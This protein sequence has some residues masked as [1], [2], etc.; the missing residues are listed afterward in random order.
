MAL[1]QHSP[2]G[3]KRMLA[4]PNSTIR[5]CEN[6]KIPSAPQQPQPQG[7]STLPLPLGPRPAG[8]HAAGPGPGDQIGGGPHTPFEERGTPP[9]VPCWGRRI[10]CRV[11]PRHHRGS[12]RSPG[13]VPG[14]ARRSQWPRG[15]SH[16]RAW[17]IGSRRPM[18][19]TLRF[20]LYLTSGFASS[21][22]APF[23]KAGNEECDFEILTPTATWARAR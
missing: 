5:S 4:V 10:P 18:A 7:G 2:G 16:S 12:R 15:P 13:L 1:R 9:L 6:R 8:L 20:A 17:P 23:Q 3:Q 14:S 19:V 11:R 22:Q 21:G